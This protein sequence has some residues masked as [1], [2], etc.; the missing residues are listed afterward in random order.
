M[1][2]PR[3]PTGV[4]CRAHVPPPLRSTPPQAAILARRTA[5]IEA[6]RAAT[7]AADEMRRAARAKLKKDDLK[8]QM[9]ME[10]ARRKEIERRK[11][12]ELARER[13]RVMGLP[14]QQQA[15]QQGWGA[16]VSNFAMRG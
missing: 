5:S 2:T 3:D 16:G 4:C 9:D 13:E 10:E 8:R 6:A 12:D 11:A 7:R 15:T 1:L 14:E